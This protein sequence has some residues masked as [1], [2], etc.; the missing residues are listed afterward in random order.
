MST[1]D[2]LQNISNTGHLAE[3]VTKFSVTLHTFSGHDS[4]CV[5][6]FACDSITGD[7]WINKIFSTMFFCLMRIERFIFR[8]MLCVQLN[9][10]VIAFKLKAQHRCGVQLC[11]MT[12]VYCVR[13]MHNQ[14]RK[15]IYNLSG[16]RRSKAEWK[17]NEK[18]CSE[19]WNHVKSIIVLCISIKRCSTVHKQNHVLKLIYCVYVYCGQQQP[20]RNSS[21]AS[22]PKQHNFQNHSETKAKQKCG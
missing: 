10:S 17:G 13:N 5:F 3:N 8:S 19:N 1:S 11:E 9:V 21:I 20:T 18:L 6:F 2:V 16:T 14:K 4:M 15:S 7:E 12:F 22:C